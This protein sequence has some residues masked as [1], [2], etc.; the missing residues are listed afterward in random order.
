METPN[1]N[2]TITEKT[3]IIP[4]LIF[5]IPSFIK[6]SIPSINAESGIR[7]SA[8]HPALLLIQNGIR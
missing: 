4:K 1:I 8:H 7:P 2:I 3:N 5:I 6:Y